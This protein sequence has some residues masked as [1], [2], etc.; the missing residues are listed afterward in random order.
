[1]VLVLLLQTTKF[2]FVGMIAITLVGVLFAH[3]R[4]KS[5]AVKTLESFE[6]L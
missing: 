6:A 3:L 1:M 5:G 2:Q 4:Y